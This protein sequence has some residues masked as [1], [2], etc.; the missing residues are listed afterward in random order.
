[1]NLILLCILL[2]IAAQLALAF[3]VSRRPKTEAD[4]LL[5]G[6]SLGPWLATF[7]VFAT[8]FGAETC[9]GA[10]GEAYTHGLSGVITDPFGY[11]LGIVLLGLFF[12]A[13]LWK[14]GL[15][16]L[17]DLFRRRYG[18]GVERLAAII[19]IPTSL[20][21][22]AA[23]IRAFGQVLASASEL[24]IFAAITLAAVVVIAYTA[25]GGMWADSVTDLL[26]GIVLI[27]GVLVL[28]V[29]IAMKGGLEHLAALPA[30]RLSFKGERS[31]L[32]TLDVFAVPVLSAI[33][34]QELASRVL[35][36]R[37]PRLAVS[38][39]VTA[40]FI[41]LAVGVVPVGLGLIASQYL[42]TSADPEQVLSLFARENLSLP[43][44]ILF[45]GALVSAIL[46]TL[47]GALLVAAS[48]AAHNVLL[49]LKPNLPESARLRAN[50][51]AVILFGITAYGMALSSESVYT[52]VQQSASFG[53]AGVLVLM[54]FALWGGR[55]GG[56]ASAYA[57]LLASVAVYV[58]GEN[59]DWL[60]YPYLS[61]LAAALGGYV[62]FAAVNTS[63]NSHTAQTSTG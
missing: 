25:V 30:E 19:M 13:T 42:G 16:T 21:W 2:Y 46:S 26:Q 10:A 33:A 52:L 45:L 23:Q 14:R 37:S 43:L 58:V 44:Y 62:L 1:M 47:S 56:A 57:A 39:T 35:A 48:L 6:R 11:A 27:L 34:A 29:V 17:A 8:W 9:I 60:T 50:R 4:Y 22:A 32:Q 54:L 18:I 51:I 20:L 5:A 24:G 63:R 61:S 53:S 15:I 36:M 55:I 31:W 38:A 28:A 12:A 3:I 7:S 49:P 41:Y 59:T 40:G